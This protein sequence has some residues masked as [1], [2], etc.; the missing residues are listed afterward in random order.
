MPTDRIHVVNN[1]YRKNTKPIMEKRRRER[2][3]RSLEE[4][5]NLI[6][7]SSSSGN[8]RS[9][10]LEKADILEMTVKHL[11]LVHKQKLVAAAAI[12]P[13]IISKYR[14]GYGECAN[15]I[16]RF[17]TNTPHI[18]SELKNKLIDHLSTRL[19]TLSTSRLTDRNNNNNDR[20]HHSSLPVAYLSPHYLQQQSQYY[21][22]TPPVYGTIKSNTDYSQKN[23][24]HHNS[25]ELYIGGR[26]NY[27][28]LA[29]NSSTNNQYIFILPQ[30]DPTANSSD[31]SNS[32]DSCST[33]DSPTKVWRP[34]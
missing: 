16:I 25:S 6:L 7:D 14:A 8:V 9:H 28:V 20:V 32:T 19:Q 13:S 29:A 15:E 12:D 5:K 26:E 11:K 17:L 22:S 24:V 31:C 10:K 18:D 1:E 27:S 33:L 30:T 2:I 23:Q 21:S 34:W 4:L 3:N